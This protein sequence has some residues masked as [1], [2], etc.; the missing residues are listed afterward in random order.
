M[1]ID[2]RGLDLGVA[3]GR[4]GTRRAGIDID[5]T[6]NVDARVTREA[7]CAAADGSRAMI[8]WSLVRLKLAGVVMPLAVAETV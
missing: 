8:N 1:D 7:E 5:N 4:Q 6:G 2:G 3:A